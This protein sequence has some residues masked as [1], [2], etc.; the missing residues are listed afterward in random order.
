MDD[1]GPIVRPDYQGGSIANLMSS[2]HGALGSGPRDYPALTA[3]PSETL[4][5]A[6]HIVLIA[7]DGLGYHYLQ[8]Q[9]PGGNLNRHLLGSMTSVFPS[10]TAAAITT[11][12]TGTAPQQHGLT[13]WFMYLRELGMVAAVLPFRSRGGWLSLGQAGI[14]AREVLGIVPFAD[15][16]SVGTH[17]VTQQRILHS[18]YSRATAGRAHRHGY[19]TLEGFF[20]RIGGLLEDARDPSFIYGYWPEFDALAHQHGVASPLVDEHYR[21]LDAAF[22]RF[23]DRVQG[24]GATL[25]V[26]ADHG[27]VDTTPADYVELAEHPELADCLALPLCGEPRAAYCY[28][29]SGREERFERYVQE[30]L[31]DYCWLYRSE[32]L[33][34]AGYF[35]QGTPHP[36]L[37]ERIGDYV[38]LMKDQYAV[39]DTI[40]GE[41]TFRPIGLHG[42]VS[43]R[44]MHVPL[45]V[46]TV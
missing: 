8:A 2:I 32:E 11:F 37:L 5:G 41:K 20:D 24:A 31:S 3:L 40:A 19:G 14:D 12:L 10:T 27:F 43:A 16:L 21:E 44:E 46:V 6:R 9:G 36:R 35:G 4:A 42:G 39:K 45:V 34:H 26:T 38:L 33:F 23:V 7:L 29:R 18:D 28:V 17:I 22:G 15:R 25:V 13:G 30:H 1:S